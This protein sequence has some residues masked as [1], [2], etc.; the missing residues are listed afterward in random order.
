MCCYHRTMKPQAASRRPVHRSSFIVH[1]LSSD[2]RGVAAVEGILLVALLAGVLLACMLLGQWGTHRQ[3]AQMGA[4]LR[5]FDAGTD[6]VARFNR[7]SDQTSQTLSRDSVSWDT[8]FEALAEADWINIMFVGLH[9]DRLSG[10]R[11]GTQQGRLP[12]QG[13]SMFDFSP[14][15]VG[16][17]SEASAATNS[18]ADTT[19]N[20]ELTFLG[21]AYWVGYNETTPEGLGSK[22]EIPASGLPILDTIY[23]RVGV[24]LNP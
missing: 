1:R 23:A 8:Y 21:I 19:S 14:A 18:W 22:P 12:S 2:D 9:N 24:P 10:S 7:L 15:S 5:T 6:S 4:R 3:Y 17:H 11:K 16:Y 13:T 20:V